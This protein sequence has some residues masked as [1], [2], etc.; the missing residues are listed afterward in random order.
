MGVGDGHDAVLGLLFAHLSL[1]LLLEQTEGDGRL[2]SRSR[3]GDNDDA[4]RFPLQQGL[5]FIQVVLADVLSGKEDNGVFMFVVQELEG[6]REGLDYGFGTQVA[7][8][9]T[10][11]DYDVAALFHL[12]GC[13]FEVGQMGFG[14]FGGQV[15]PTQKVVTLAGTFVKHFDAVCSFVLQ[16]EDVALGYGS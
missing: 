15:Q 13:G 1:E 7:A 11:N 4:E 12:F 3:F 6:I 16:S 14:Y 8:A 5:Q 2:G 9:D 10:D